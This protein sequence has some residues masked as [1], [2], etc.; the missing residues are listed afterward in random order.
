MVSRST[1]SKLAF[2]VWHTFPPSPKQVLLKSV[3]QINKKVNN[4]ICFYLLSIF[5]TNYFLHTFVLPR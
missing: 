2:H 5:D 3:G 4:H 1:S